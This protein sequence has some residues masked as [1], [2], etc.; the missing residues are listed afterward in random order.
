MSEDD[1][2]AE[3]PEGTGLAEVRVGLP[4]TLNVI[5]ELGTELVLFDYTLGEAAR[6]I[7]N[8]QGSFPAG[9]YKL[10]TRA[11]RGFV[12]HLIELRAG[13]SLSLNAPL[14]PFPSAAP[15]PETQWAPG[16]HID[17]AIAESR[18]S[19]RQHGHGASIFIFVRLANALSD[20]DLSLGRSDVRS[21]ISLLDERGELVVRLSDESLGE[22]EPAPWGACTVAVAP[23][24]YRL[25]FAVA[26][27]HLVEQSI[28]ACTGW[29][30]QV[31]LQRSVRRSEHERHKQWPVVPR[32]TAIFMAPLGR[33]FLP[34]ILDYRLTEI[35]RRA[36]EDGDWGVLQAIG[37]GLGEPL[38]VSPVVQLLCLGLVAREGT[39]N[40][41][42]AVR[43]ASDLV[44]SVPEYPDAKILG[45]IAID[46][47][48]AL[49]Q[50]G[51]QTRTPP[52]LARTWT[53][54]LRED[55]ENHRTVRDRSLAAMAATHLIE[56][57]CWMVWLTD[58]VQTRFAR[59]S[60]EYGLRPVVRSE[61]LF[62]LLPAGVRGWLRP[63]PQNQS[64][65]DLL[66]GIR[67]S[68]AAEPQRS[69]WKHLTDSEE[70]LVLALRPKR[71]VGRSVADASAEGIPLQSPPTVSDLSRVLGLPLAS[72][73]SLIRQTYAKLRP[74]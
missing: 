20:D 60:G 3:M 15:L 21:G 6:G 59:E 13:Q 42:W 67:K 61:G 32:E 8:L 28:V 12:D 69:Q 56:A 49:R 43:V 2:L 36:H 53:L 44:A 27:S 29:Q 33:G 62:G 68:V 34:D 37:E 18:R 11:G 50:Q 45:T 46:G 38:T 17:A 26:G 74:K 72:V 1:A 22:D 51:L 16:E 48:E 14:V 31:F 55:S 35:A 70:A 63:D 41:A 24:I 4:A 66:A 30:T 25:R 71:R 7:T 10:R 23:G 19:E 64:A 73:E 40:P 52:M 57:G 58:A 47:K 54:L 65:A 5:A 9:V 39:P